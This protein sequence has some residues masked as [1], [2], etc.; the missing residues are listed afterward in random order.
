VGKWLLTP[1]SLTVIALTLRAGWV[2]Y[3]WVAG[4][5]E[6]AYPDE[7]VHWQ[8]ARNLVHHGWLITDDG[9]LAARMPLYPLFLALFA[10]LGT[11]GV[12]IARLAQAEIGRAHV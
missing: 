10:G 9:R 1:F 3:R 12:L 4:G 8:L 11:S 6:S 2:L 7:D 5:A